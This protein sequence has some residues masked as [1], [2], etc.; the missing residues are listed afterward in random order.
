[1]MFVVALSSALFRVPLGGQPS[2]SA[3]VLFGATVVGIY[4]YAFAFS[5]MMSGAVRLLRGV[6]FPLK[7]API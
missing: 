4:C 5:F 7:V 2:L 1:M 3:F 6:R